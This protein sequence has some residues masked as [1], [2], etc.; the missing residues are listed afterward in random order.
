MILTFG[1]QRL[2]ARATARVHRVP[3]LTMYSSK[4]TMYPAAASPAIF[5]ASDSE[6][7]WQPGEMPELPRYLTRLTLILH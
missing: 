1:K 7:Q 5:R 4:T 2:A 6:Y 3:L